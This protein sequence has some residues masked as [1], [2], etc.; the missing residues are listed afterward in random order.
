M[1]RILAAISI[2]N[3][4]EKK[5]RSFIDCA[6]FSGGK[7]VLAL[8]DNDI[9]VPIVATFEGVGYFEYSKMDDEYYQERNKRNE[10]AVDRVIEACGLVGLQPSI[11]RNR[12]INI[13]ELI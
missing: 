13:E 4:T 1:Q 8:I 12:P 9:P 2:Y 11:L 10:M 7:L 3:F 5:L 6:E